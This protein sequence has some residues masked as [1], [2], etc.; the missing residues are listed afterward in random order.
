MNESIEVLSALL[1]R[2]ST[3]EIITMAAGFAGVVMTVF[4]SGWRLR[5]A[6][7]WIACVAINMALH[8]TNREGGII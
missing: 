1:S 6:A 2:L 8:S 3:A 5:G 7:I 4:V